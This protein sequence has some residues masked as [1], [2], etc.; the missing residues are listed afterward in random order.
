MSIQLKKD[1]SLNLTKTNPG[2]TTIRVGLGWT[3]PNNQPKV[4]L[5]VSVLCLMNDG[6]VVRLPSDAFMVFYG[7]PA[8]MSPDGAVKHL[9]DNRT[10]DGDG[11]DET[12]LVDLTKVDPRIVDLAVFVTIYDENNQGLN[13]SR[14]SDAYIRVVNE[15]TGVEIARADLDC[16]FTN[17]SAV[18]FGS[19]FRGPSE[20]E[21]KNIGAGYDGVDLGKI[22]DNYKPA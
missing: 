10:G 11:D 17:Q 8:K 12:V 1:Q 14:V 15:S 2:L 18:Q 22:Y 6:G 4:D 13:F 20:W 3:I 5:D 21:F 7:N 9:G 16:Q 19:I